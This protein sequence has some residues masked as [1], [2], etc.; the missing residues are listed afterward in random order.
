MLTIHKASAGSGKTYTLTYT[1]IK[2]LLGQKSPGSE[3]YTL[4]PEAERNRH[5]SILAITFTNKATDEMKQRI[6]ARLADIAEGCDS[7]ESFTRNLCADL[8][9][10]PP[11]LQK[12]AA[13]ALS[14][15]LS[16]FGQ[17][18]V[19]TIDSFF[20][21]VL[22]TF[23][24]E[25]NLQGGYEIELDEDHAT[26]VGVSQMLASINRETPVD[27]TQ[28]RHVALLTNWLEAYMNYSI[29]NGKAFNIFVRRSSINSDLVRFIKDS[30]NEVYKLN[31]TVIS[32]YIADFDRIIRFSEA[33]GKTIRTIRKNIKQR[34][35]DCSGIINEFGLEKKLN[36]WV[37]NDIT[38][39]C[40]GTYTATATTT[41]VADNPD[42][43]LKAAFRSEVDSESYRK[44]I[45]LLS[46]VP[47][48]IRR[49]KFYSYILDRLYYLGLIGEAERFAE[50]YLRENNAIL[51]SSTNS[52]LRAII[53]DE[54]TPFIY[55]RMGIRLHHF[56]IDEFQD[57]SRL[58]WLN[59][60]PL[61]RES[62]ASDADNLIIG[63]EKQAIYRFRNSDPALIAQDVPHEFESV[64]EIRGNAP[65]E[66]TNWR[67]AAT[68]VQFNNTLFTTLASQLGTDEIYR[69]VAQRIKH[70]DLSGYVE[71]FPYTDSDD[72]LRHMADSIIRQL[73]AGYRQ[74]DIAVL[75]NA[76]NEG[77][78]VV[79]FLLASAA[80]QPE[81][82]GLKI[83]TEE[84]LKISSS[85][86]IERIIGVLRYVD[87]HQSVDHRKGATP[88]ANELVALISNRY[89][90]YL[91]EGLEP[92]EALAKAFESPDNHAELLALEAASMKCF[93]LTSMVE[94]IISRFVNDDERNR[95]NIYISA[96]L[97]MVADFCAHNSASLHSFMK[98]WNEIG[99]QRSVAVPAD[100]D[101]ITVMTIHK[102]KGLE[103]PCVHIPFADWTM[104][105]MSRINWFEVNTPAIGGC[106]P[107][108]SD[109]PFAPD[110]VPPFI[111]MEPTVNFEGTSLEHQLNR[112]IA[113]EIIDNLNKTYVAFTRAS[114]E[115]VV[116][117]KY[118]PPKNKTSALPHIGLLINSAVWRAD[119]AFAKTVTAEKGLE[120]DMLIP[121]QP[122][123]DNNGLFVMGQPTTPEN[124][125]VSK[126]RV[127]ESTVNIQPFYSA[128][129]DHIWKMN[130]IEDIDTMQ[131][132]R[133]QG[134]VYHSIMSRIRHR[135]DLRK[136]IT[137]AVADGLIPT[138]EADALFE[139]LRTAL[140]NDK[141][142]Q[143][144]DGFTRLLNER[145]IDVYS[146]RKKMICH[147]RPD[148]VVWCAD[149]SIH[150]VDY[151]FGNEEPPKYVRQVQFYMRTLKKIYP[152]TPIVGCLWWPLHNRF[153][154]VY[155][156]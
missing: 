95:Q 69:N 91:S 92:S 42:K 14:E 37:Y 77:L 79:D 102:S 22:R 120:S 148:R 81:L 144:F 142:H 47:E 123:I 24:R 146:P 36:N 137:Q 114:R 25:V 30:L 41:A 83:I 1:Y 10:S 116:G 27:D 153:I 40:N 147:Y 154:D 28:R 86:V 26:F 52:I 33:L 109:V 135:T 113:E 76:R 4:A 49:I 145:T 51:L 99:S 150:V 62:L 111:P 88:T 85:P 140:N 96:L 48:L 122:H 112:I 110:D 84:A 66:N 59:L 115:L 11:Q 19:S 131:Q 29:D 32:D 35:E 129:N 90:L 3:K 39:W 23:A 80:D 134:I 124:K 44:L 149:G 151:K 8:H 97:D 82:N 6:V 65:T 5:R 104:K 103:Y 70:K 118:N 138:T 132:P 78:R 53:N 63:D 50:T 20:Q 133:H 12:R 141:A 127:K 106:I 128:D 68:V 93:N 2:L 71:L 16:D 89:H 38:H 56:L 75:V 94:R 13:K 64:A 61:V 9:C 34:G 108:F 152:N 117:Y 67:S 156:S 18:N 31:S 72:S 21:T 155:P 15:L 143:W 126:S 17:F 101:A 46:P 125:P 60:S 139:E 55:E 100:I 7:D 107:E 130:R 136:S 74:R 58:Q 119:S 43:G 98:W 105:K 54:E 73:R 57:T 45:E 87:A 121:L